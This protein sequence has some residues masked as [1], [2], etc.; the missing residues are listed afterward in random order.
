MK[1][2]AP[3]VAAYL[4][5]L[6]DDRREALAGV[7]RVILKNLDPDLRECMQYG[8]V[9]YSVSR[10]AWPHGSR[11][12]PELPLMYMGFSSQKNDMVVYMLFL[13]ENPREREWFEKAWKAAGKPLRMNTAGMACCV[14]FKNV[15]ELSLDVIAEAMRRMPVRKFLE[16]HTAMLALR[17]KGPDGRPL[18]AKKGGGGAGEKRTPAKRKAVMRKVA[19]R[20]KP[21]E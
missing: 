11:T 20:K 4:D 5:S 14:R 17:G 19:P 8:V 12:R 13:F 9:A 21:V 2:A 16:H 10:E 6:P 18:R 7:R 3:T 15:E 1:S